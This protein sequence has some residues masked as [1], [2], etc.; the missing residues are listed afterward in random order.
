MSIISRRT[1]PRRPNSAGLSVHDEAS[2]QAAAK[3]LLDAGARCIIIT[4]G[5]AG[6]LLAD[7][8]RMELI[9]KRARGRSRYH[10]GG[11]RFQRCI[12]LCAGPGIADGRSGAASMPRGGD[13]DHASRCTT[14][15]ADCG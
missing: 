5:A 11:R 12:C 4:L 10:G 7:A 14:I 2:A 3:E 6:A 1:K 15:I 8:E 9:P 13:L